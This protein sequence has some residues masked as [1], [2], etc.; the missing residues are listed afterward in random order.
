MKSYPAPPIPPE[1]VEQVR[2]SIAAGK[3][4]EE[5]FTEM[6]QLGLFMG[7][8]IKLTHELYGMPHGDAKMAVHYS[9]TWADCREAND[10]LHNA[11]FAAAKELGFEEV[12]ADATLNERPVLQSAR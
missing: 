12:N 10:V 1:I 7:Q 9:D 6:R 2:R 5:V 11:A 3:T 8:S 4:H